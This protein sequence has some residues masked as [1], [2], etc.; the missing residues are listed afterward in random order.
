MFQHNHCLPDYGCR[1][2]GACIIH[3]YS[4]CVSTKNICWTSSLLLSFVGTRILTQITF[5]FVEIASL[6]WNSFVI[7]FS[8]I[9]LHQG[10]FKSCLEQV[11]ISFGYAFICPNIYQAFWTDTCRLEHMQ[12]VKIRNFD[13]QQI[14]SKSENTHHV[15]NQ[16]LC[17][18]DT[19]TVSLEPL[20]RF[21]LPAALLTSGNTAGV[22]AC[23]IRVWKALKNTSFNT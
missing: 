22:S 16:N 5:T 19:L 10:S 9:C 6:W 20:V 4:I 8:K 1:V 13:L 11:G 2:S 23:F 21:I 17:W 3:E 12:V 18:Q 14:H 15:C 7:C